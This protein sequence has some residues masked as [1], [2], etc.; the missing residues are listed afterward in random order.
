M[1][2]TIASR[3]SWADRPLA[4]IAT[5]LPGATAIF[6]R[7]KLDFCCGGAVSLSEAARTRGLSLPDLEADLTQIAAT[8]PLPE[9]ALDTDALITRIE[10]RFHAVHRRELPELVRLAR[11]VEAVH[12][13]NPAVPCGLADLLETIATELE[14]HMATEEQVL[15]PLMRQRDPLV[16][17]PIA[18]M[19]AQHDDHGAHLR[20]LEA[21]THDFTPPSGA[22]TTWRALYLG[23]QKLNEDLIE[24]IHTENNVLF[25]RFTGPS[26]A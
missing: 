11:R 14:T 25:P 6:R 5:S 1:S 13:A 12:K 9:A 18:V 23:A 26:R 19:L 16:A 22:C 2:T 7:N 10:T 3:T 21:L 17:Q 4:E 24:H 8:G 15:F 20:K